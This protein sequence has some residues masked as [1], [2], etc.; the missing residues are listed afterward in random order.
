MERMRAFAVL[1][2][3]LLGKAGKREWISI[4][5]VGEKEMNMIALLSYGQAEERERDL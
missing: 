2:A 1:A 5:C 3:G 4:G